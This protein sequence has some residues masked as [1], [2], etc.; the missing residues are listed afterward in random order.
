MY[1][2]FNEEIGTLLERVEI[3]L[4]PR[5]DDIFKFEKYRKAAHIIIFGML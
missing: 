1:S 3:I 5:A 2:V 4:L